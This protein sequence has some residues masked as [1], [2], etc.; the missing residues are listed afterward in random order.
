MCRFCVIGNLGFESY[1][2]MYHAVVDIGRLKEIDGLYSSASTG[3]SD[4]CEQTWS[5]TRQDSASKEMNLHSI[6]RE[7][8]SIST[9]SFKNFKKKKLYKK[10]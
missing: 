6:T 5:T 7:A 3:T 10:H 1:V 9:W 2:V 4:N 8:F